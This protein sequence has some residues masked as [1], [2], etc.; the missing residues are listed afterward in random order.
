MKD[1]LKFFD[2]KAKKAFMSSD[3]KVVVKSGRRFA[4]AQAPSGIQSW[5]VLG[6]A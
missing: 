3:Y 2:L 4:V 1:K 6:M 5:R